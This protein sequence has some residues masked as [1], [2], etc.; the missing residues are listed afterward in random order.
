MVGLPTR[1]CCTLQNCG[2]RFPGAIAGPQ[3][4]AKN[5][6]WPTLGLAKA[7][8]I[9]VKTGGPGGG[10]GYRVFHI[11]GPL[12]YP[13]WGPNSYPP[14]TRLPT[15]VLLLHCPRALR[16]QLHVNWLA[17]D[18]A[19]RQPADQKPTNNKRKHQYRQHD[20]RAA[21]GDPAPLPS[22]V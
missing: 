14:I 20:H 19:G 22:L 18:R 9:E 21:G 15:S 17:F 13:C 1:S 5:A 12:R 2:W 16:T 3:Q 6:S 7:I 10:H 8:S 4:R 11:W